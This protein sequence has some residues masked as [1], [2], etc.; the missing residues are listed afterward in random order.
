MNAKARQPNP[1]STPRTTDPRL[2]ASSE[3]LSVAGPRRQRSGLS[4][5]TLLEVM[6]ACLVF[7]L[8]GFAVLE[9]MTRSLAIVR[10][11]QRPTIDA[12][13]VASMLVLSNRLEEG[14]IS[15]DFQGLGDLYRDFTWTAQIEEVGSNGLFQVDIAVI[16]SGGGGKGTANAA[17][18]T[19][20]MFRPGSKP[21]SRFGS[22]L[23]GPR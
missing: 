6:I 7:F 14:T 17:M 9:L 3:N 16:D 8:V 4:A 12:G 15:G 23:G 13:A 5:F 2:P 10:V 21:G 22:G 19:T 20:L 18:L 1:E 11:I